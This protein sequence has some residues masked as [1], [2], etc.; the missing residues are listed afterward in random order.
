MKGRRV[1]VWGLGLVALACADDRE[2]AR[3]PEWLERCTVDEECGLREY[4]YCG[5]CNRLCDVDADCE[6][7]APDAVCRNTPSSC[8]QHEAVCVAPEFSWG[9]HFPEHRSWVESHIIDANNYRVSVRYDLPTIDTPADG[10]FEICWDEIA[11]DLACDRVEPLEAVRRVELTRWS[12]SP[13]QVETE[14][15][16]PLPFADIRG[17]HGVDVD[18]T[19]SCTTLSA[20]TNPLTGEPMDLAVDYG[21]GVK[22]AQ[23]L[24]LDRELPDSAT[25]RAALAPITLAFLRPRPGVTDARVSAPDGCGPDADGRLRVHAELSD[26]PR[27]DV[28]VS[29]PEGTFG[30]PLNVLAWDSVTQDAF[31]NSFGTLRTDTAWVAF[32]EGRSVRELEADVLGLA[33]TATRRWELPTAGQ[34]VNLDRA[35]EPSS[36]E[37]FPGFE[38]RAGVWLFGLDCGN[39]LHALPV[40]LVVLD[41]V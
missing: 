19:T 25:S 26:R 17:Y 23:L 18:G 22:G 2:P 27:V 31:G 11:R 37:R 38:R 34:S 39:C 14:L 3:D 35:I 15:V 28:L 36:G 24:S 30:E 10:D 33:R 4:C 32:Y 16:A 9:Y 40:I 8:E 29:P 6:W 1:C 13:R 5:I 21:P 12:G 7:L 20:M 41:P